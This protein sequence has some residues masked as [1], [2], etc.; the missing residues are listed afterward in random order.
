MVMRTGFLGAAV[1]VL[2]VALCACGGGGGSSSA[3]HAGSATPTPAPTNQPSGSPSDI[4][5]PMFGFSLPHSGENTSE[6][7]LT[8][9]TVSK[10]HLLWSRKIGDVSSCCSDTQPIVAANVSVNGSNIDVVFAG[11]EHGYFLALNA[12]S[13]ATVWSK[14]LGSQVTSCPQ[15]P[16]DVFGITSTPVLD[17]TRN[18][19]YV[20]DGNGLLYA[21]DLATGNTASGWPAGGVGV[22]DDPTVDHVW[23]AL[24]FDSSNNTLFVTTASYCDLG[25]WHGALRAVNVATATS[26][27]F[28]FGTQ[29]A[30]Q[31]NMTTTYGGGIWGWGG[32]AIDATTHN[33]YGASGNLVNPEVAPFSDSVA[34]WSPPVT[35]VGT[36]E[37]AGAG[38]D[39]DF[40]G[41]A[42][43][44]DD[45]GSK[46]VAAMRK[47]GTL[48]IYD[49]T[50]ISGGPK[51]SLLMGSPDTIDTP[52][53]SSVTH[54]LYV[55][56]PTTGPYNA[57]LYAFQT[58][59]GCTINT[60]AVW[61]QPIGVY[62]GPITLAGGVLFDPAGSQ[63]QAFNATSGGA[64]LWTSG[65]TI[66]G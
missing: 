38:G 14:H 46:C 61:S 21:Y 22:V 57:G 6:T 29:G 56:N 54:L 37:P 58:Q 17:R 7:T 4:D 23:S 53:H 13:G 16:D 20:V 34:E 3:P 41:S 11:D 66:V 44:Y 39:G 27:V 25:V 49:R 62:V 26:S 31:P 10:L 24:A 48:F 43:L 9:A 32:I 40:G 60:T 19:V 47:E 33:L 1:A 55:N 2:I 42:I 64:P 12:L 8:P 45:A 35:A 18:R 63:L 30:M 52:A 65:S 36:D 59:A 51:V 50:N 15:T 5:W 28:Y